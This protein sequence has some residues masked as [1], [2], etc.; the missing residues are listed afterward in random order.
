MFQPKLSVITVVYN[1][2][3]AIERTMLSV[4]NQAYTNIEY[5]LID[6]LS[7]DG[8][9]EI[10]QK[11]RDRIQLVS[12]KDEGIYDAMNKGIALADVARF[13]AFLK[14]IHPL[15]RGAVCECIGHHVSLRLFLKPVVADGIGCI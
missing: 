6:G 13:E 3:S 11:Y 8:T 14:P 5:I 1:D 15:L 4:L 2:V 12:E 10:I 7:T 9:L